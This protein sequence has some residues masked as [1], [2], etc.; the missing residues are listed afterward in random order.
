MTHSQRTENPSGVHRNVFENMFHLKFQITV[1]LIKDQGTSQSTGCA[2]VTFESF[3]D[4]ADA[5]K[6]MNGKVSLLSV[7]LLCT[8][9][10][11]ICG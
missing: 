5:A 1:L 9:M 3:E 11:C 6:D 2:F 7:F 4:A 10:S 8:S